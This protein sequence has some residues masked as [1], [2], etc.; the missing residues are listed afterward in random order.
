[1][2][3]DKND[4]VLRNSVILAGDLKMAAYQVRDVETGELSKTQ[5]H[6]TANNTVLAV[7]GEESAKLFCTFVEMT[8]GKD[9]VEA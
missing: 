6:M 4:I 7:M 8:L 1:M 3:Y 5:F 9:K 2:A